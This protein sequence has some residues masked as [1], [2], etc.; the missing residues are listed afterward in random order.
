MGK[1]CHL[2][3]VASWWS[4]SFISPHRMCAQVSVPKLLCPYYRL[5]ARNPLCAWLVFVHIQNSGNWLCSDHIQ[6][7][8]HA[9]T[10]RVVSAI[11]LWHSRDLDAFL[12]WLC[13]NQ[14]DSSMA[15]RSHNL[16]FSFLTATRIFYGV[17]LPS[18][19]AFDQLAQI[20]RP[21][22]GRLKP[23][24]QWTITVIRA[25]TSKAWFRSGLGSRQE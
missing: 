15:R 20:T 4:R 8:G 6:L 19:L 2:V 24:R 16:I 5:P 11:R 7:C 22:R 10:S 17:W 14:V 3:H 13:I 23:L 12:D 9:S 21:R 18:S 1:P 25:L